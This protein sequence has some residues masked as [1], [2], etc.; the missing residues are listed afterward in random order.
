MAFLNKNF[1]IFII[2]SFLLNQTS[3]SYVLLNFTKQ[4]KLSEPIGNNFTI[5]NFS[6]FFIDPTF[7]TTIEIGTPSQKVINIFI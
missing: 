6:Q 5:E 7:S 2:M 4:E 1:C 3:T